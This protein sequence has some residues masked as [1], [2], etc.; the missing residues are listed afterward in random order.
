MRGG[1]YQDQHQKIRH[2]RQGDIFALPSGVAH[3]AYNHGDEPLVAIV[4]IDTSNQANQLDKD[5][6]RVIIIITSSFIL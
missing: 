4:L 6:P 1:S 5:Y 3:W 2:L